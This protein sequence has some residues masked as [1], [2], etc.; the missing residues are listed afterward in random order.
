MGRRIG[1]SGRNTGFAD[2]YIETLKEAYELDPENAKAPVYL[3]RIHM[4]YTVK[5]E[6]ANSLKWATT[7][8]ETFPKYENREMV[9]ESCASMYDLHIT[10]R[11]SVKVRA[12]YE[13][14]INEYP[15]MDADKKSGIVNRLKYNNLSFEEYILKIVDQQAN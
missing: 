9:L 15:L 14:L 1:K 5:G 7:L 2:R 11:D 10:P 4:W 12:I 6:Y 13:Q 8:L 3:D